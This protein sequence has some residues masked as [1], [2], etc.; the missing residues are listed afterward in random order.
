MNFA[1]VMSLLS[2]PT[3]SCQFLRKINDCPKM[4][5][6]HGIL[7]KKTDVAKAKIKTIM[8]YKNNI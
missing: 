6:K 3:D 5:R 7:K 4:L 2:A 8:S 1:R